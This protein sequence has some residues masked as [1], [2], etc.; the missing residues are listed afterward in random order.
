MRRLSRILMASIGI[1]FLVAVAYTG[2]P[3]PAPP[4]QHVET[5]GKLQIDGATIVDIETGTLSPD[6]SILMDSGRIVRIAPVSE[7][8]SNPE[9]QHIDARGQYVVPGYNNMH[10]HVLTADNASAVLALMLVEGVTGFR[11]M[12]GSPEL[13]AR[14]R[15]STL[16]LNEHTPALLATPG[17]LLLPFNASTVADAVEQ[18]RNQKAEGADFIKVGSTSPEVFYAA[19]DEAKRQGIPIV[20]HLPEGV[21]P[22]RASSLGYRSIEHLGP[23]DTI[24]IGCSRNEAQLLAEAAQHPVLKA[25]PFKMP[26]FVQEVMKPLVADKMRKFLINP[27]AFE[28]EADV[29]RMQRAFDSYD[30]AKCQA[31]AKLF[32]ENDTWMVPT[33]VRLRTQEYADLP[34]YRS[35]PMIPYLIPDAYKEWLG[36]ADTFA[37]LPASSRT[38]FRT[39]YKKQLELTRMVAEAGVPM[40][41][42]TDG[43]GQAPGEALGQEFDQLAA[44][45]LS[46][47]KILQMT[48]IAPARFLGRT[49]TMGTVA[50][51]RDADLVLFSENPLA[52][53]A[54]LRRITGV[55]R[56]GHYYSRQD[57]DTLKARIAAGKGYLR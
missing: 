42:G 48:T 30:L 16:P 24:W 51:G 31:L 54:N 36:A 17:D 33:L 14:R 23:G 10:S 15:E 11:Q 47:L 18:I 22:A 4:V 32:A 8:A 55:V 52:S 50:V 35:D 49:A 9:S 21:D 38:T 44:A 25:P 53:V 40:M 5:S 13:L 3:R 28:E 27:A 34:E 19:L 20:G 41:T 1:I 39:A 45:G 43:S 46:P 26:R 2:W 29:E 7:L 37:K 12:G 57:L 6:R 56:A